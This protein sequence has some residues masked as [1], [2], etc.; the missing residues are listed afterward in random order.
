MIEEGIWWFIIQGEEPKAMEN[1]ISGVWL[2][3]PWRSA[4]VSD[5]QMLASYPL[6]FFQNVSMIYLLCSLWFLGS[7][8]ALAVSDQPLSYA[9]G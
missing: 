7:L 6:I 8:S 5:Y 9:A 3:E 4:G 1:F 2:L